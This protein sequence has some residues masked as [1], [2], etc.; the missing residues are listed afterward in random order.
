[1]SYN[2]ARRILVE[3]QAQKL[4]YNADLKDGLEDIYDD[5]S[6][7]RHDRTH[8]MD[9]YHSKI[10]FRGE[11]L[12]QPQAAAINDDDFASKN[13]YSQYY[14][15]DDLLNLD[16]PQNE[17]NKRTRNS[18]NS[19]TKDVKIELRNP[20]FTQQR[21]DSSRPQALAERNREN[22]KAKYHS[23]EQYPT[24]RFGVLGGTSD[25]QQDRKGSSASNSGIKIERARRTNY[26]VPNH[27][28]Y[29]SII[30]DPEARERPDSFSLREDLT[31]PRKGRPE[32]GLSDDNSRIDRF[33]Y[34]KTLKEFRTGSTNSRTK[35]VDS[36]IARRERYKPRVSNSRGS[37]EYNRTDTQIRP[38][39]SSFERR[40]SRPEQG[41]WI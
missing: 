35:P 27:E 3:A 13:F 12:Q 1:M 40:G 21:L 11:K 5:Y 33:D 16:L 32:N 18:G 8:K 34:M 37:S 41:D 31:N 15:P 26:K 23:D 17:T 25:S 36:L 39:R 10:D 38:P 22:Y 30:S 29:Y 6:Y 20:R 28:D 19:F 9:D 2:S 7:S 4:S 14:S 24:K